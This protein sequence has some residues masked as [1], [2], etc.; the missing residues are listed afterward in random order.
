MIKNNKLRDWFL[1]NPTRFK[2]LK[3]FE[4]H[5][6]KRLGQYRIDYVKAAINNSKTVKN[7]YTQGRLWRMLL[8]MDWAFNLLKKV[9][10]GI[11]STI[12][13]YQ[14][15]LLL[16]HI[17]DITN[18]ER[19]PLRPSKALRDIALTVLQKHWNPASL[20]SGFDTVKSLINTNIK[21]LLNLYDDAGAIVGIQPISAPCSN[22]FIMEYISDKGKPKEEDFQFEFCP[23]PSQTPLADILKTSSEEV[24]KVAEPT[25]KISLEVVKH[26]VEA[27]ASD[28]I[29]AGYSVELVQDLKAVHD[30]D[31]SAEI[32]NM[33]AMEISSAVSKELV[34]NL[35][36]KAEDSQSD[37]PFPFSIHAAANDIARTTRRGAGNFI[38]M[39]RDNLELFLNLK[40]GVFVP[41]TRT[42]D[43]LGKALEHVGYL[44]GMLKVYS[45]GSVIP[46]DTILVGYKGSDLDAGLI[47]APYLPAASTGVVINPLTFQPLIS[48]RTWAGK[49]FGDHRYYRIIKLD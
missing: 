27:S 45:M 48:F 15:D 39:H 8:S 17:D 23:F 26:S 9:S 47:Y 30:F 2:K 28:G 25:L 42:S 37:L 46:K 14:Y 32:E 43:Q 34:Q 38:V 18:P 29:T 12:R 1:G 10:D 35:L 24:E 16:L 7:V 22:V 40:H 6:S 3:S 20:A 21:A 11:N 19:H 49:Y 31:V 5:I 4:N 44:N 41:I 13:A 33:L 36:D